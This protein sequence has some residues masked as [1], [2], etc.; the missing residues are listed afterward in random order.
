M[1]DLPEG[2]VPHEEV[3]QC[4]D[5]RSAHKDGIGPC[6]FNSREFDLC[7]AGQNCMEFRP[8]PKQEG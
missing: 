4:G 5:P 8:T 1:T 3:C 6:K 2:F 7:H